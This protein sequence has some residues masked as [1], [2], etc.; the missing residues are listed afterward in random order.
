MKVTVEFDSWEAAAAALG[1]NV[2][3]I[4]ELAAP[5]A[6][7]VA[8]ATLVQ[9]QAYAPVA[10]QPMPVQAQAYAPPAPAPLAAPTAASEITKAQIIQAAQEHAKRH[11]PRATKAVFEKFGAKS[12]ANIEPQHFAQAM[13][14]FTA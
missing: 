11:S 14:E 12:A 6:A 8:P 10:P 9:A 1:R 3:A 2:G 5:Y 13:A 4:P 7:Q